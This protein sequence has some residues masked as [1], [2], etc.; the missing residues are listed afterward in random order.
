MKKKNRSS[1]V[2][3]IFERLGIIFCYLQPTTH[4]PR[5]NDFDGFFRPQIDFSALV[6]GQR[7]L[8]VKIYAEIYMLHPKIDGF[9]LEKNCQ[10][11]GSRNFRNSEH[12]RR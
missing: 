2:A 10:E 8:P 12:R 6:L 5:P 3:L 4:D 1:H 11:P 7:G 9:D